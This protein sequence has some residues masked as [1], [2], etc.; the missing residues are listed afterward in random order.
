MIHSNH[1]PISY[2]VSEIN[3]DF[4][5]K[6]LIFHTPCIKRPI[7][8][9][10]RHSE[11]KKPKNGATVPRKKFDDIFSRLDTIVHKREF[12]TDTGRQ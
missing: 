1:G 6:S 12:M 7:G 11:S 5:R 3:G 8:I 9:G 2:T 4:C 10:Y